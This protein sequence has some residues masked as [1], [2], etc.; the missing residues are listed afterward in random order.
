MNPDD[1]DQLIED[2]ERRSDK[3]TDWEAQFVDSIRRQF[4]E[5][6]SLSP[7]QIEKLEEVWERIT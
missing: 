1:I 7:K 4:D 2:C 3:L 6:G 5:R